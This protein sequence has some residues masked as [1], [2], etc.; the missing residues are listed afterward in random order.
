MSWIDEKTDIERVL[1]VFSSL[2]TAML[3]KAVS[4]IAADALGDSTAIIAAQSAA[5]TIFQT[6]LNTELTSKITAMQTKEDIR[7]VKIKKILADSQ[8]FL[9][10]IAKIL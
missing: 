8:T 10:K 7:R 5:E 1:D 4:M 2:Q 3:T 6:Y 9:A